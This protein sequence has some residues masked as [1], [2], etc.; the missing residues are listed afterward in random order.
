VVCTPTHA[1]AQSSPVRGRPWL[2]V[3]MEDGHPDGGRVKHVVRGSPAEKVGV[4]EGDRLVEID[5]TRA[6]TAGDVIRLV[7]SHAAGDSVA[8][9]IARENQELA[10][11]ATL[12]NFPSPDEMMRMDHV[13]TFAPAWKGVEAAS[14]VVPKSIGD[15]KGRVV[16][17][18]FWATWCAPCRVLSPKLSAMQSRYGAQGLTVVGLSTE[19]P[20]DVTLFAQRTGMKYGVGVD[21]R[22][23]TSQAYTVASLPTLFIIDKRGVVREIEVGYDP[24]HDAQVEALVKQL[25]AEPVPAN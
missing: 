1:L 9:K 10:L 20:D 19:R 14:G 13:G 15:L 21:R 12:A 18:D 7:G 17:L 5:G 4:K 8:L 3:S 6:A 23:E 25:L 22:A 2:G 16:L 11:T 24:T